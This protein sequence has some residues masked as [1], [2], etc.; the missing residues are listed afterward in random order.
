MTFFLIGAHMLLSPWIATIPIIMAAKQVTQNF[1]GVKQPLIML[2]D[3]EEILQDSVKNSHNARFHLAMLVIQRLVAGLT[4][5]FSP[6]QIGC[7]GWKKTSRDWSSQALGISLALCN[8]PVLAS[9]TASE[10][11]G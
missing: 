3:P 1:C 2:M 4:R 7:L 11:R 5:S 9:M 6:S 8:L 10:L